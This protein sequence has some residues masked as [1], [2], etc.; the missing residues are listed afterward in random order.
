MLDLGTMLNF[1]ELVAVTHKT[2]GLFGITD[3]FQ[4]CKNQGRNGVW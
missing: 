3:G 2:Y 1:I 4:K